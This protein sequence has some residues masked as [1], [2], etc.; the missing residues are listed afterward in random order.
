MSYQKERLVSDFGSEYQLLTNSQDIEDVRAYINV[1]EEAGM[2]FVL[3]GEAEYLE[4]WWSWHTVPWLN[5]SM[6]QLK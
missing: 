3:L 1:P 6:E 4:I 2:L 5:V